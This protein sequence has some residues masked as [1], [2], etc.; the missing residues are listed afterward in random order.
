M[1]LTISIEGK[2][3]IAN[4][5]ALTNDTGGTG[6][7]DWG[8]DGGGSISLTE[9]VFLYGDSCIAGAYSNKSGYQYFN[10]GAG[11]QLDF[12]VSGAE[13]GQHIYIWIHCPTIGLLETKSNKGLAIR[14]GT[15]LS[16]YREYL[17]AGSDDANGWNGSWK[18]FVIDP[19]KTG[20]VNDTGSYD[21]GSIQYLGVWIEAAGL[22][23]GD[24]IFIS[25]IAVGFG[26]RIAGTSTQGWKDVV[27]YCTDYPNRAWGMFQEREGIYYSYGKSYIGKNDQAAAVSFVDASRIIQ[28]G[29]SEYWSG[30]A[31]VTLADIDY[32]GIVIEDASGYTT[33]FK[34][35]VVSGSDSGRSGSTI[36]GN[37]NH[38][39]SLDLYGGN[40]AASL[41]EIYGTFF[42]GITGIINFGNDADHKI[43]S[44]TFEECGQVDPVGAPEI[45][46]CKFISTEDSDA[47][48]L[49]NE[50]ID[51]QACNFIANTNGAA[52]EMPS[53]VG[54]PYTYNNLLFSGNTHDVNN[55]SG[56]T[57]TVTKS[58]NS[59]PSSYMGSTVNFVASI[60][61]TI[62]VKDEDGSPIV[63]ASAY[64]DNDDVSPYILNT[65]T[66]ES[67]IA[68]T[69][70]S[71]AT[72][73]GSRWRVRKYGY[74][75]FSQFIDIEEAN[76]SLPV[77]LIADSLQT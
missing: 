51:I 65:T 13:E 34:D 35:G 77:T 2:G 28:F 60:Q 58:N 67:G 20:S 61:L 3:V 5:D 22:A 71:G 68:T 43:Y 1:A 49:W 72:I 69:P 15:S 38:D 36:I 63:G 76:I 29:T 55:T 23:K 66:N 6:T 21:C 18:C 19:T 26:L 39:V 11:N 32:Q 46:N 53:A 27:D 42:K 75:P 70:Y 17:I 30:S 37:A 24:N 14:L 31:W 59:N 44:V 57:L 50:N 48:L 8:E 62:T 40:E 10:L 9:D 33:T 56:S 47:A 45:R 4:A 73:E 52:I 54:S 25:R 41:T 16:D 64:I 7:G 74:K 12:D